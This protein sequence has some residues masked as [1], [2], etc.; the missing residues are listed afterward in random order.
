M[1]GLRREGITHA[2]FEASSHG[3]AQYRPEGLTVQA[4]AFTNLSRDHLDYHGD[5]ESY[6]EAKMRLFDEVIAPGGTAVIWADDTRSADVAARATARG[7]SIL[8]IGEKGE[9][10]RLLS[11]P[12]THLGQIGRAHL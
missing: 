6:F 11:L 7:L 8:S 4:G 9:T 10:L 3:L 5:M 2:A 1:A 12:P